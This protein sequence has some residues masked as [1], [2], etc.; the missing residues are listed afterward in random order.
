MQGN[1]V[2][3]YVDRLHVLRVQITPKIKWE[4][5]SNGAISELPHKIV[6][7]LLGNNL[8]YNGIENPNLR[9]PP[10]GPFFGSN[11]PRF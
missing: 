6:L 7:N 10:M 4:L 2:L 9:H 1:S 3:H 5:I 11:F 8:G